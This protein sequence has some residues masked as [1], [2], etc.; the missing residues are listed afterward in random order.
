M[1]EYRAMLMKDRKFEGGFKLDHGTIIYVRETEHGWLGMFYEA[2]GSGHGFALEAD[3]FSIFHSPDIQACELVVI[4][5]P[6]E[7]DKEVRAR[8]RLERRRLEMRI[9]RHREEADQLEALL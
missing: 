7:P 5:D 2:K 8:Q 6:P 1:I 4:P 3:D 9:R